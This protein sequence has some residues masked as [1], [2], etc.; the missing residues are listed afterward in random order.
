[1]AREYG[2][3]GMGNSAESNTLDGTKDKAIYSKVA[4]E[5]ADEEEM[6]DEFDTDTEDEHALEAR[7]RQLIRDSVRSIRRK[8]L[9]P[10]IRTENLQG[11]K[12]LNTSI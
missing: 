3:R 12:L 6:E 4:T 11:K 7:E 10:F 9:G 2:I 5:Q 8:Q 1:M